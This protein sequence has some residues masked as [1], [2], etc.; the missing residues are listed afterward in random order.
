MTSS[1]S[2]LSYRIYASASQVHEAFANVT[3]VE[4][5]V[6]AVVLRKGFLKKRHPLLVAVF[7]PGYAGHREAV[8]AVVQQWRG[9]L[10]RWRARQ[11]GIA[12]H[13]R[14][15]PVLVEPRSVNTEMFEIVRSRPEILF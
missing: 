14:P 1:P 4:R 9:W 3:A 8:A 12:H 6:T 15:A 10:A 5:F 13:F 2:S 7:S 11:A